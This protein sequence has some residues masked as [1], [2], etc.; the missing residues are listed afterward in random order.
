MVRSASLVAAAMV[1]AARSPETAHVAADAHG[2]RVIAPASGEAIS[3]F[4]LSWKRL[5]GELPD[6]ASLG[7][8][9][10]CRERTYGRHGIMLTFYY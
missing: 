1:L 2:V 8:R 10:G 9:S 5:G 7:D 3:A 6:S 4:A